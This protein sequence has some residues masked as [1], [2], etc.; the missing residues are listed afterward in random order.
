M[1]YAMKLSETANSLQRKCNAG[2]FARFAGNGDLSVYFIEK[3]FY[4]GKA[5]AT[6][7]FLP[8][9]FGRIMVHIISSVGTR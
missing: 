1:F 3:F 9:T 4:K 7:I 8:G 5:H 2:T 6:S